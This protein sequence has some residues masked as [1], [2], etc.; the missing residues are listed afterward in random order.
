MIPY[1][2]KTSNNSLT[3]LWV[4]NMAFFIIHVVKASLQDSH[5][6]SLLQT[7]W[8]EDQRTKLHCQW[9]GINCDH[10]GHITQITLHDINDG[11]ASMEQRML[12]NLNFTC[13]PNLATLDLSKA[14]VVGIIP[15]E[16]GTLTKLTHLDLSDNVLT[17]EI[18]LSLTNLSHLKVLDLSYNQLNGSIPQQLGNLNSLVSLNLTTNALTGAIPESIGL[19]INLT[20]LNMWNNQINGS[21]PISIGKLENLLH[22]DLNPN[23]LSGPIPLALFRLTKLIHLDISNNKLNGSIPKA[24][25]NLTNLSYLSIHTNQLTGSIP[26]EIRN[27]TN[28]EYLDLIQNKLTGSIPREIK[29]LRKLE[30]LYLSQNHLTG[31]IPPEIGSLRNLTYLELSLNHLTGSLP[32][33]IGNLRSL[34]TL[35]LKQNKFIGSIPLEFQFLR[36]L[37]YLDLSFN[38]ITGPIFPSL[39][40]LSSI[41]NL[42]LSSNRINGSIGK[43]IENLSELDSMDV[44]N[45]NISGIIPT[46]FVNLSYLDYLNLSHNNFRGPIQ[47]ALLNKLSTPTSGHELLSDLF[48]GNKDLCCDTISVFPNCPRSSRSKKNITTVKILLI[49]ISIIFFFTGFVV[50]LKRYLKTRNVQPEA[51]SSTRNGDIFSIWNFDGKIAFED[52]IKATEEFDIRYCIG[53]GGYGSVYRAQLPSGKVIALKKLH[54]SEIEKPALKESFL[55]EVETLT[56][57]RHKSIVQL[58]GYC[59]HKRSMF[60]IY[61]YMERGSLFYV[62]NNDKEAV[63][64]SWSKRVNVIKSLAHALSYM[65]HDCTPSIVHRDVTTTNILLNSELEAF[66]SDFGTARL[67]DPDFSYQTMIA[68]T[69]GYI[70]PEFAYTMTI[71]EKCDVFS[72]GVVALETLMG[73]HPAELLSLVLST[74]SSSLLQNKLLSEII[75]QRL[76]RPRNRFI[77]RDVVL[78]AILAFACLNVQPNC[79]PTML[80]VSQQLLAPKGLLAKSFSDILVGQLMIPKCLLEDVET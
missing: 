16:I 55:N 52:I 23:Y 5:V 68:G 37:T 62:L 67:V 56:K 34:V 24:L 30:S 21:I 64:L 35:D 44:S 49:I 12:K 50:I 25:G 71:T 31:S 63:D 41:Q 76:S 28:L 29:N 45:N 11:M 1:I 36:N 22:L 18:P 51:K 3:L 46:Q 6:F 9:Q 65:H 14:G 19:L 69:Y 20:H 80:Q 66:L 32:P 57:I 53:T 26:S 39:I 78:V 72:F 27:L 73:K 79:R 38:E 54:G 58:H 43:D 70:A 2:S 8:C 17:G 60:L 47:D 59:L 4:I 40:G 7:N 75:D 74:S 48:I 15:G 42:A 13:L 61:E 77:E 33:Q 10:S